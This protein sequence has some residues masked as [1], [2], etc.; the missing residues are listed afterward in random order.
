[1][2]LQ[3]GMALEDKRGQETGDQLRA[4]A[5]VLKDDS[6]LTLM[7]DSDHTLIASILSSSIKIRPQLSFIFPQAVR[8]SRYYNMHGLK[9]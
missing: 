1:M 7:V 9:G 5:I 8:L 6:T 3:A 4:P 2:S